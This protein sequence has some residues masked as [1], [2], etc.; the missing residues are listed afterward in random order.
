MP[1]RAA[2]LAAQADKAAHDYRVAR[3]RHAPS[4]SAATKT[5]RLRHAALRAEL[6]EAT[7]QPRAAGRFAPKFPAPTDDQPTLL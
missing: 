3:K 5:Y 7:R 1:S 4:Q 2:Y 6:E